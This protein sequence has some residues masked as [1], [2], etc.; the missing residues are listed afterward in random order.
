MSSIPTGSTLAISFRSCALAD[1]SD[2]GIN[3]WSV[4]SNGVDLPSLAFVED[5]HQY[6]QYRVDMSS[7]GRTLP[8]LRS[9]AINLRQDMGG[10]TLTSSV[11]DTEDNAN[12]IVAL[13][14]TA[15]TS[16]PGT[17]LKFQLRTSADG[18]N[19]G[20]WQ[21]PTGISD[22]YTVSG[23]AINPVHADG[24]D[25]RYVQYQVTLINAIPE[26]TPI[27]QSVTL[28]Y[29]TFG[30][31]A[32]VGDNGPFGV[33]EESSI[34]TLAGGGSGSG[35][36][37]S[38]SASDGGG[39]AV[40]WVFAVILLLGLAGKARCLGQTS[41]VAAF[42]VLVSSTAYGQYVLENPGSGYTTFAV[43]NIN[44]D[45]YQ[46]FSIQHGFRGYSNGGSGTASGGGGDPGT[47]NGSDPLGFGGMGVGTNNDG[48]GNGTGNPTKII[49]W[50]RNKDSDMLLDF[51]KDT[52]GTKPR[53]MQTLTDGQILAEFSVDMRNISYSDNTTA[54]AVVNK[55]TFTDPV[56]F[57]G[58]DLDW[59]MAA[60]AQT[61]NLNAGK[62]TYATGGGDGGS[63]GTY[64]YS[65]GGYDP[66]STDW[67]GFFDPTDTSN[68]WSDSTYKP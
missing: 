28:K 27:L 45:F 30:S 20:A 46:E 29:I 22:F 42:L 43:G 33:G 36:S 31:G 1:C 55:I 57:E 44:S 38:A 2:R 37:G 23:S 9:I 56:V 35:G 3:D 4:A 53:I 50:Q 64:I 61:S 24:I 39:G 34:G 48:T 32:V 11:Y 67:T 25:D 13:E 65:D 19:W 18:V 7:D 62:Y 26:F 21:G 41:G 6:L 47:G 66:L 14:W 51:L 17:G 63:H 52:L 68:V 49:I 12:K 54:A 15:D 58:L 10:A 5:G 59:D 8:L 16:G 60:D 40:E